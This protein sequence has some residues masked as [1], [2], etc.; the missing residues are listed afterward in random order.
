MVSDERDATPFG[1]FRVEDERMADGR[2]I[3]YYAW[4]DEPSSREA[5]EAAPGTPAAGTAPAPEGSAD[6]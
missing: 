3:H 4:P 5:A 1:D 6:V 2:K